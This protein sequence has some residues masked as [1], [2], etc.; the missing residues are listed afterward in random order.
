MDFQKP[1]SPASAYP[2]QDHFLSP[3]AVHP[4]TPSPSFFTTGPQSQPFPAAVGP[5]NPGPPQSSFH[6][7]PNRGQQGQ[8]TYGSGGGFPSSGNVSNGS[9]GMMQPGY[10]Q[11]TQFGIQHPF[12]SNPTSQG[13]T[14]TSVPAGQNQIQPTSAS[15]RHISPY[16]TPQNNGNS[17]PPTPIHSQ[18]PQQRPMAAPAPPVQAQNGQQQMNKMNSASPVSPGTQSR[19]RET[20][21]VTL[22]LEINR[23][24]LQEVVKLQ[25]EGKTGAIPQSG[26]NSDDATKDGESKASQEYIQAMRRLQ[27]NLS[28]LASVAERHNKPQASVPPGPAIMEPLTTCKPTIEMYARLRQLFPNWRGQPMKASPTPQTGQPSATS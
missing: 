13:L 18:T 10:H 1:F 2:A 19:E 22:L 27:A 5:H 23:E 8:Q 6:L 25:A 24:L 15:P 28:Y 16:A 7:N 21:R 11:Q 26:Q 9:V 3:A 4:Q 17:Q 12:T 14:S 20:E